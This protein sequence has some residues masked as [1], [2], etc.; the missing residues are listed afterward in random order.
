[1][2]SKRRLDADRRGSFAERQRPLPIAV[3]EGVETRDDL[4]VLIE[5]GY[6]VAQGFLFAKPMQSGAFVELLT[7][8]A[9]PS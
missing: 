3:A 4:R 8:R 2:I 7:A 6:P 1:M 5:I 9:V